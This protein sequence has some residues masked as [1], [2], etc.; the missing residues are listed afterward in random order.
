M[1]FGIGPR[2]WCVLKSRRSIRAIRLLA[3]SFTN[4]QRPSYFEFGLRKRRVMHIAP[5]EIAEHLFRF[6]IES[7]TGAR[8]RREDRNGD[9]VAHRWNACDKNLAGVSAGI[10][11]VV[12]ILLAGGDVT[13]ERVRGAIGL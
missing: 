3:L 6:F 11:Q 12:F 1:E 2:I 5:G 9:D 4:S 7:V 8:I 13:G 10:E